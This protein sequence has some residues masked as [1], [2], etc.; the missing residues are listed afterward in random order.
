MTFTFIYLFLSPSESEMKTV[1]LKS[2][3]LL[4][5]FI[6]LNYISEEEEGKGL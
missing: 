5:H 2:V 3:L 6:Q 1:G 4:Y